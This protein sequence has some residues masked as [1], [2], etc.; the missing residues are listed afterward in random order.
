VRSLAAVYF[1]FTVLT[2]VGRGVAA[3]RV[4]PEL[5]IRPRHATGAQA[6][7]MLAFGGKAAIQGLSRL[8]LIQA[9]SIIVATVLGPA[10][11]AMYSRCGALVRHVETF[12]SKL[13]FVLVP[14]ASSLQAAGK[15]RQLRE[16][17]ISSSRYASGLALPAL[18]MLAIL[19]DQILLLWMG[20]R[21]MHGEVLAILAAGF[22]LPLAQQPAITILRGL[23]IHRWIAIS[24]IGSAVTGVVFGL[25][26]VGQLGWGMIGA[27]L[28]LSVPLTLGNG[29]FVVFYA[30][31][32]LGIPLGDYVLRVLVQ[33]IAC[34]LPFVLGLLGVRSLFGHQPL[35]AL[36]LGCVAGVVTL[37][38]LYWKF[39][40]PPSIREKVIA[41]LRRGAAAFR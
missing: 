31:R 32:R 3:H 7:E 1:A 20:E 8:L 23:D 24:S 40:L 5:S 12:V 33:P 16:L 27:A 13:A 28:A 4:C 2:Q 26:A 18:V 30:S 37:T 15:D 14:T 39:L 19:G 25:V 17:M 21:Y 38:P 34:T 36:L 6:R 29:V 22:V 35:L 10:T 9:N 11:L 41:T